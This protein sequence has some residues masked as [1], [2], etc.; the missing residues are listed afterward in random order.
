M[1]SQREILT[2]LYFSPF[3]YNKIPQILPKIPKNESI[4]SKF[5]GLQTETLLKNKLLH[6]YFSRTLTTEEGQLFCRNTS[7]W[8]FPLQ[9]EAQK[10]TPWAFTCSKLTIG[11]LEQGVKYVQI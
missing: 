8:L 5:T 7:M 9:T 4:F 2:V 10:K 1:H 11:T 3:T 6:K